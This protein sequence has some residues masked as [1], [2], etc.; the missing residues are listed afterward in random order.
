[1]SSP[2]ALSRSGAFGGSDKRENHHRH[3]HERPQRELQPARLG[4]LV[5]LV[6]GVESR[7]RRRRIRPE[8]WLHHLDRD[9]RRHQGKHN[10]R[11]NREVEVR[12]HVERRKARGQRLVGDLGEH[13]VHRGDEQV[14]AKDRANARKSARHAGER[15]SPHREES[16]GRERYQDQVPSVG[17]YG[18]QYANED[19]QECEYLRGRN[20]HDLANERAHE[21][22]MLGNA[23]ASHRDQ[24][25]SHH[26]KAGK[27]RHKT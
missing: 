5:D 25:H 20:L 26:A 19:Q 2:V 27:V 7:T 16:R 22:R 21:S 11:D 1:M 4:L 13:R 12:R 23:N 18:A 17:R 8:P 9:P 6:V 3:H 24:H 15:I 10:R 14:H